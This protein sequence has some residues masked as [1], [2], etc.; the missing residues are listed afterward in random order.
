[1][2]AQVGQDV[3]AVR[4]A[5]FQPRR[6]LEELGALLRR[7][8][9]RRVAG[10]RAVELAPQLQQQELLDHIDLGDLRA[11]ARQDPHEVIALQPLQRL[12]HG[13]AADAELAR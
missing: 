7:A 8:A 13:R 4:R 10:N 5:R 1:M 3:V 6:H 2:V 11:V 9:A 12:P